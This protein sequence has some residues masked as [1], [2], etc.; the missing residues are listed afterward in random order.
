M[1]ILTDILDVYNLSKKYWTFFSA[2]VALGGPAPSTET[3]NIDRPSYKP[4]I[5]ILNFCLLPHVLWCSFI[6]LILCS[7][8]ASA[9]A[10]TV[11]A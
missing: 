5:I 9:M 1:S 6:S 2:L 3:K 4:I 8:T 7:M 10:M 11:S